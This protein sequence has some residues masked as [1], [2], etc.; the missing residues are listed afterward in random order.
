MD[1][2]F[3]RLRERGLATAV[4]T[5]TSNPLA[6]E[7]VRRAGGRPDTVVGGG[8]V[9]RAKPEPDMVFE[10]C[11]RLGCPPEAAWVVGDSDFDREAARRAGA[12]F[13]GIHGIAGE[14]TLES[15][16]EL[17]VHV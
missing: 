11:R 16:E 12:R 7:L 3:D 5:N 14:V 10:A 2:V 1:E 6:S 13:A 9:P 4:V 15:L 17:L 8:D